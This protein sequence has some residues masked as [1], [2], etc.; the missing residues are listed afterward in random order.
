[1]KNPRTTLLLTALAC[2]PLLSAQSN[3]DSAIELSPFTVTTDRDVGFVAANSLSGGRTAGDLADTPVAYSVQTREF[4]DALNITSLD[5]AMEWA[6]NV[7]KYTNDNAAGIALG[8]DVVTSSTTRG[9]PSN[10]P[11]RNFFNTSYTFDAYNTERFDYMRGPNAILFGSGSLSGSANTMTKFGV[12]GRSFDEIRAQTDS[13]GSARFNAD[14]N[15]QVGKSV[16]FRLNFLEDRSQTWRQ[17]ELTRKWGIAPSLTA[18]LTKTTELKISAEYANDFLRTMIS[19][20]RDGLS[21][22]DGTTFGLQSLAGSSTAQSTYNIH[23]VQRLGSST[24]PNYYIFTPGENQIMN[25]AGTVA[26]LGYSTNMRPLDGVTPTTGNLSLAGAPILDE[27]FDLPVSMQDLYGPALEYSKFDIPKRRFTNLGTAPVGTDLDKDV[28]VS[29]TQQVGDNLFFEVA[30][31]ANKRFNYGNAS[32]WYADAVTGFGSVYV[33]ANQ[34]LPTGAPNPEFLEPYQQAGLDRRFEDFEDVGGHAAAAYVKKWSWMDLKVNA[35]TG[36]DKDQAITIRE[37]GVL[38]I[39]ADPRE[40]GLNNARSFP[41]YYRLYF[42]QSNRGMP[43]MDVP[44]QVVNPQTGLTSTMTP[45]WVLSTSRAEGGV[46][47]QM[48]ETD[49]GQAAA[50]LSFFH[51]HLVILGAVREDSLDSSQKQGLRAESYPVGWDPTASHYMW[52]PNAPANWASLAPSRPLDSS[53]VPLAQYSNLQYQNDYNPP[54]LSTRATTKSI[55]GIVNLAK[56]FSLTGNYSTTFQPPNLGQVTINYGTPPPSYS[57]GTDFGIRYVL[58]NGRISASLSR[59]DAETKDNNISAPLGYT[60]IN[61]IINTTSITNDTPGGTNSVGLGQLPLTWIDVANTKSHGYEFEVVANLTSQWRLMANVGTANTTQTNAYQQTRA[62]LTANT[63][64]LKQILSQAGVVINSANAASVPANTP[65]TPSSSTATAGANAWNALFAD[66]PTW[67]TG[68]QLATYM[69]KYTANAFSDYT[70]RDHF[71]N[72]LRVGMGL[73]YRGPRVIGFRG[74]DTIPDPNNPTVAIAAPNVNPYTA[75]WA[76]SYGLGIATVFYP[77][78]LPSGRELDLNL[79]VSNLFDFRDPIYN[80]TGQRPYDGI[81]NSP[82][83][84]R[85]PID[86]TYVQPTTFRLS[87]D[88][89]F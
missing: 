81:L 38:P 89:R 82:A 69:V 29:L 74:T 20:L 45:Q 62:W 46:M 43:P 15:R 51:H 84:T 63:A 53:G 59:Y 19:P 79:T 35:M 7:S 88:Y 41:V 71:L 39:D 86:Y 50:Q 10:A 64:T 11:M 55:G 61:T 66:V 70:F 56:G 28:M 78:R 87:A 31:D 5:D 76:R 4:L 27:P 42:D 2:V 24:A 60:N 58:P 80:N 85:V 67:V 1:M 54:D 25:Y 36:I 22:W 57:D 49:W 44:V 9:F 52:R 21:G 40:W 75:I 65:S 68:T 48:Q 47:E 34:T 18:E 12:I 6:P 32:Y 73:Q 26:T 13:N 33:D 23:G 3:T 17:D 37:I 30:G 14:V 77:I 83:R 72:G 8:Q 16:A